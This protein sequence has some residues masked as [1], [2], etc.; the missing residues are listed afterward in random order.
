MYWMGSR[1]LWI[2]LN[3]RFLKKWLY[4]EFSDTKRYD[5]IPKIDN[6]N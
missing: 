6:Y 4:V 2:K 5:F 3:Q 1:K